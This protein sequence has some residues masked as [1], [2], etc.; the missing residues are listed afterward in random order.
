[1][2]SKNKDHAI[3]R[4]DFIQKSAL[5]GAGLSVAAPLTVTG[6]A[7]I[8]NNNS[9]NIKTRGYAAMDDS[10]KLSPWVFDRRPVGDDDILIEIKYAMT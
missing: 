6:Q 8:E 1:M 4:R 9:G 7:T 2:K 5:V 3:T 10:G